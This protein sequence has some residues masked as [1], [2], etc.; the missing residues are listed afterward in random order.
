MENQISPD[1]TFGIRYKL[2][3]YETAVHDRCN[4][5]KSYIS[6]SVSVRKLVE[7]VEK[8]KSD[9]NVSSTEWMRLQFNLRNP[10]RKSALKYSGG[11]DVRYKVQ[12]R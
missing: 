5:N 1:M 3:R 2:Y 11:F 8:S 6:F 9:I 7:R 10:Y 4:C 12:R